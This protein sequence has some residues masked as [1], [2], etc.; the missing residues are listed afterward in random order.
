MPDGQTRSYT[1]PAVR[2]FGRSSVCEYGEVAGGRGLQARGRDAPVAHRKRAVGAARVEW[3]EIAGLL[4]LRPAKIQSLPTGA[5]KLWL[6]ERA[7]E[8]WRLNES[9]RLRVSIETYPKGFPR[10]AAALA[11]RLFLKEPIAPRLKQGAHMLINE[12][13]DARHPPLVTRRT[14]ASAL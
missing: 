12:N 1:C 10:S 7:T 5:G 11:R 13:A 9:L 6:S 2:V 4:S 3:L 14:L 8:R